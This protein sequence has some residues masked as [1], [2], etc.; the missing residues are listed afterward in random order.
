MFG[1]H[2][3]TSNAIFYVPTEIASI[4]IYNNIMLVYNIILCINYSYNMP[5]IFMY[6]HQFEH[7]ASYRVVYSKLTVNYV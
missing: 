6:D 2:F 5:A 1:Y 7:V 4:I 3:R